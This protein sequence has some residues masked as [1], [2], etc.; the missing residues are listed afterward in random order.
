MNT[1]P[2][3]QNGRVD[4]RREDEIAVVTLNREDK[5]NA[6]S[7]RMEGLILE[8][9]HSSEVQSS[10]GVVVTGG[11]KVF[12]AG[13]DTTE[14]KKMTPKSIANYYRSTG[15]VYET[16]ANLPQPTIA[17]IAGYCFGGG[18]ELSLAAD[19]RIADPSALFAFPEITLGILPSSGGVTRISRILGAGRSRDLILRARRIDAT[20]A[21]KWGVITEVSEPGEHIDRAI[22]LAHE[23][24]AYS[25][26]AMSFTKQALNA[27]LE[28]SLQASLLTEQ[29]AYAALS[30]SN[31]SE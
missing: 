2:A 22:A 16:F 11:D 29:L 31:D 9:L 1:P 21:E 10:T 27:A 24:A 13:A 19:F 5:L 25:P 6:L 20:L 4:V 26:L 7:T 3:D 30:K 12:S 14:L 8:A 18:L 17:S 28:G 23:L 15:A